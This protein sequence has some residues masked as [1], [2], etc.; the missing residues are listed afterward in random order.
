MHMIKP[1]PTFLHSQVSKPWLD[2]I[3]TGKKNL[4]RYFERLYLDLSPYTLEA[5]KFKADMEEDCSW[6]K[7]RLYSSFLFRAAGLGW[8][9]LV[10]LPL[11]ASADIARH[12][13][14]FIRRFT[15]SKK[16]ESATEPT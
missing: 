15:N 3:T 12:T 10:G 5:L 8:T 14:R 6:M 1:R 4:R 7:P 2:N 9:P 13:K 11:A 16:L